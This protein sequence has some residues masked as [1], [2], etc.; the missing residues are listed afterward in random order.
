MEDLLNKKVAEVVSENIKSAHVFKKYGIDF[1][2]GG[3]IS[4]EE[5]CKKNDVES[6][7]LVNDLINIDQ[8]IDRQE[9]Y[10]N[11]KL[12]FLIQHILN[13]HHTYVLESL[14]ILE[15]YAT[16]VASVHG[17]HYKELIEIRDIVGQV[18]A[19]L[20]TH[21]QKEEKVLFPYIKYLVQAENDN[22]HVAPPPF[23]YAK[24]PIGVM[25]VEHE[26]AGNA[27]KQLRK[28]SHDYKVPEDACNTFRALYSLLEEFEN[29]L[30]QHIHLEN[31]I[32]FPKSIDLETRLM[33][34]V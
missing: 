16:K 6:A 21:L 13:I 9:D 2:C 15:E 34:L 27:F 23:G 5:A 8:H 12:D 18:C 32:L 20:F 22:A 1:C 11:W 33:E 14:P 29:D 25:E 30:H 19:E 4:I 17:H 24:S 31:N 26:N 3:G 10:N 28:L 7:K